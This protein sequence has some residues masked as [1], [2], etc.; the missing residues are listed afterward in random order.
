M[1]INFTVPS[2]SVAVFSI[3]KISYKFLVPNSSSQLSSNS[4]ML[5]IK[6]HYNLALEKLQKIILLS[7]T[8]RGK[9][10]MKLHA[11]DPVVLITQSRPQIWRAFMLRYFT[12]IGMLY[13]LGQLKRKYF[14]N[15]LAKQCKVNKIGILIF[16]KL[17]KMIFFVL[18]LYF[19]R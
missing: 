4:G 6:F 19:F 11:S 3:A 15:I 9:P 17:F 7:A 12:I 18:V 1:V 5:I 16:K 10:S 13:F 8:R 14:E 2:F